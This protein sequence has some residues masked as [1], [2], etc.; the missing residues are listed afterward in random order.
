MALPLISAFRVFLVA[1]LT[2]ELPLYK[3]S[4]ERIRHAVP[5]LAVATVKLSDIPGQV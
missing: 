4:S 5:C 1:L 2:L 3:V